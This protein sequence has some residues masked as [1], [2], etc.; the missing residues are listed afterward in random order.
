MRTCAV[1]CE[2][3]PLHKGHAFLFAEARKIARADCVIALM[4][5]C[6]TQRGEPACVDE[7]ARA[8]MALDNGADVVLELPVVYSCASGAV[9]AR[10]G[11]LVLKNLYKIDCVCM[12][13]ETV[14]TE[15]VKTIGEIQLNPSPAFKTELQS[16]MK[17]GL[18]Y[19]KALTCATSGILEKLGYDKNYVEEYVSQ[20]NN[21]LSLEYYKSI[22]ELQ[23][24]ADFIPV[25]LLS[26]GGKASDIRSNPGIAEKIMPESAYNTYKSEIESYYVRENEY[27]ALVLNALRKCTLE[28]I[29]NCPD[30]GEGLENR[31]KAIASKSTTYGEFLSLMAS[32]RYSNARI[33]RLSVQALLGITKE[34]QRCGYS[35]ARLIAIKDSCKRFLSNNSGKILLTTDDEKSFNGT[36]PEEYL[37]EKKA[38][39]LYSLITHK[40]YGGFYRRVIS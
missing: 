27:G 20:P 3:N 24:D 4:S 35:A 23:L 13:A 7:Y 2:L 26:I 14:D 18:S 38:S 36:L 8:K 31:I 21:I 19:A 9:F 11:M 34:M 15:L 30:C 32:S 6:F 12:G 10:G 22:K 25:K 33:K 16:S 39:E 29:K 5:G 28:E 40:P 17:K 37:I 1:F